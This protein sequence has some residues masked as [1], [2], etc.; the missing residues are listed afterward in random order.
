M[1]ADLIKRITDLERSYLDYNETVQKIDKRIWAIVARQPGNRKPDG[2]L[3][4]AAIG[5][6]QKSIIAGRNTDFILK[7]L[8]DE[9]VEARNLLQER[10]T[11][12]AADMSELAKTLPAYDWFVAHRGL[13]DVLFARLVANAGADLSE[14]A[15]PA[16]VWSRFGLAV[17]DGRSQRPTTGKKLDY[18]PRRRAFVVG[19]VG[20]NLMMQN[21]KWKSVY[22]WRKQ[23][24]RDR[25]MAEG[26][27]I[28]PASAI[29]AKQ[30]ATG[31]FMSDGHVHARARRYMVKQFLKA[32]WEE[33]TG[34]GPKVDEL[35]GFVRDKA[36]LNVNPNTRMQD[37]AD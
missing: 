27:T 12:I 1:Y 26:K 5:K 8:T 14:F 32:F 16:N 35:P 24:E 36:I 19:V 11:E 20:T 25:A 23:Y 29:T 21:P 2:T 3:E 17:V 37:A 13:K 30:Q 33:W 9:L 15:G 34:G 31:K 7:L 4:K 28:K 10:Q 6:V 22:D 18:S